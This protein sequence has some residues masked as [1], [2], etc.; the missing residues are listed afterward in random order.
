MSPMWWV[1][2]DLIRSIGENVQRKTVVSVNV[3]GQGQKSAVEEIQKRLLQN[4][5]AE[6]YQIEYGSQFE[7][8]AETSKTLL[9]RPWFRCW[10][11]SFYFSGI[12]RPENFH[13]HLAEFTIGIDRWRTS[14]F[15]LLQNS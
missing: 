14:V 5:I 13:D 11:F 2:Q 1:P 4:Q 9:L 10:S 7:T 15:G 3:A 8:E 12:Q 6:D